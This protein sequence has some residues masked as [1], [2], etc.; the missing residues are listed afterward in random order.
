MN[1]AAVV[2]TKLVE[3]C[4][5]YG[6]GTTYSDYANFRL[7]L[8]IRFWPFLARNGSGTPRDR[9]PYEAIANLSACVV[10]LRGADRRGL[11]SI[12][13]LEAFLSRLSVVSRGRL[14]IYQIWAVRECIYMT[15][16]HSKNKFWF[17][18]I[19]K[20]SIWHYKI[21]KLFSSLNLTW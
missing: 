9:W 19:K 1:T 8:K 2:I 17:T 10:V 21:V 5:P 13:Q 4:L 12:G 7:W 14:M 18:R 11:F 15:K 6:Y 20:C 3:C 16:Y